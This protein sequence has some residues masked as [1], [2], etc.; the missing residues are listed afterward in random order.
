MWTSAS[1]NYRNGLET[2]KEYKQRI[3]LEKSTRR[4]TEALHLEKEELGLMK[5]V[6]YKYG[7]TVTK[8]K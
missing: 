2:E 5:L 7:Y 4:K 3:K 6:A 8:K 1:P